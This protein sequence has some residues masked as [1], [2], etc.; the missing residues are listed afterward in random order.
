M[1]DGDKRIEINPG[2]VLLVSKNTVLADS[3]ESAFVMTGKIGIELDQPAYMLTVE[4][5]A[6]NTQDKTSFTVMLSIPD[7]WQLCSIMLDQF[8]WLQKNNQDE[9][10]KQE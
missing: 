8:E 2:E 9:S 6:N 3:F 1:V 7:A 10:P 4:G 5:R